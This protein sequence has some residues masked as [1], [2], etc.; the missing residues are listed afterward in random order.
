MQTSVKQSDSHAS[1]S[2]FSAHASP[3]PAF[4]APLVQAKCAACEHEDLLQQK[5]EPATDERHLAQAQSPGGSE[6]A[7]DGPPDVQA[8]CSACVNK[9]ID[10]QKKDDEHSLA[11]PAAP[12]PKLVQPKL[13]LGSAGD[14]F[15]QEA[16]RTADIVMRS[17]GSIGPISPAS[18]TGV[19]RDD[20]QTCT[21]GAEKEKGEE[22]EETED[23][24]PEEKKLDLKRESD[25]GSA[26]HDLEPRI[27]AARGGG[28]PLPPGTR[29]FMESRFGYDFSSVRIHAGTNAAGMNGDIRSLAFTSGNDIFFGAGHYRPQSDSG[30]HLLAHELTHVVQQ[31]GPSGGNRIVREKADP[32]MVSRASGPETKWYYSHQVSGTQVHGELE[33]M[34]RGADTSK[35]LVTEAAIPG[36][37]RNHVKLNNIGVAD[38]YK[39]NPPTTVTGIKG[40]RDVT[41][42]AEDIISMNSPAVT[43]TQPAVTSSP[44]LGLPA[45]VTKA[46][47]VKRVLSG[48]FPES[49]SLGEIKPASVSKLSD[50][51]AQLDHYE[52]GYREF[53][54]QVSKITGGATRATITTN[55]LKVVLPDALNFDMWDSQHAKAFPPA[56]FGDR[57]LWVAEVGHG[58]G[59]YLYE[60]LAEGLRGQPTEW[61]RDHWPKLLTVRA[62]LNNRHVGSPPMGQGKA[63]PSKT[64]RV[65]RKEP[66]KSV[67][68]ENDRK[69]FATKFR[70][71]I[72]TDFKKYRDKLKFEKKLGKSGRSL[73]ASEKAEVKEYKSMMFWSG[74]G[75]KIVGKV[76]FLLGGAWDKAVDIFESMKKKMHGIRKNV[77]EISESG[78]GG[79][80]WAKKLI[81]VVVAASKIAVSAFITESF[82][83]F[84]D[85][86]QSAMDKVVEKF[87]EELLGTELGQ[88]L[89]RAHK[90]FE[91]AKDRLE[92]EW[93]GAISKL[94]E[95]LAVIQETKRWIDIATTLIDLI[96]LGVQVISCLT[97]PALGCLWG[98]VAQ[99]GIGAA[100]GIVVGTQWFNDNIVTPQV[101]ALVRKYAA[102]H[103]QSLINRVLGEKLK[104]YHCHI[105]DTP[106]PS[107]DFEAKDGLKNGTKEMQ[108]HR[109]AWEKEHEGE[110]LADL[111]KV[112][113]G[114]DGKKVTK[115]ELQAFIKLVQAKK[116][117]VDGI[118]AVVDQARDPGSGSV[119]LDTATQAAE[120][121]A[122][123]GG[124]QP[125]RTRTIDYPK[126]KRS[127]LGSQK[128]RGWDP[129]TFYK[130]PLVKVDSDEFADAIY[131][132]QE[133][134]RVKADGMLGDETLI[135]FYDKNNLPKDAV[136]KESQQ[137]REKARLAAEKA[138]KEQAEKQREEKARAAAEKAKGPGAQAGFKLID[139]SQCRRP[140]GASHQIPKGVK[141]YIHSPDPWSF[142]EK[143]DSNNYH[144]KFKP[145]HLTLDI[146]IDDKHE[147]RVENVEVSA[148]SLWKLLT[149]GA[150]DPWSVN[151]AFKDGIELPTANGL[152]SIAGK[153]WRLN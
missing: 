12:L 140:P 37:N 149:T 120:K 153:D 66:D 110:M 28:E 124:G 92:T 148:F 16:D 41:D 69:D 132:L 59:I 117:N 53:V 5:A 84:A 147:Y 118:K 2:F 81:K 22:D 24:L 113:V 14:R 103:Y 40:I 135:A 50:G 102:P 42:P 138:A 8:K 75:G 60:D 29:E 54:A 51:W 142:I 56:T 115:E 52:Q 4:F 20:A 6:P 55:R 144:L 123:G 25:G 76:R 95:L 32:R 7:G 111:Q 77:R 133:A 90:Q 17:S 121:G 129:M 68:W 125:A 58:S 35:E 119:S 62:G 45:G 137:E 104:D 99:I 13:T 126:A 96:R 11:S 72:K 139:A 122:P 112:F 130:K 146:F 9:G 131:D 31:L 38:L 106:F 26:P 48:D 44:S 36:A 145:T 136:Y 1:R 47:G 19:Q 74:F 93:G 80:G 34:L 64:G 152:L 91:E 67:Q 21:F 63:M 27:D 85:C 57:R 70:G 30:R 89:C 87:K 97:P 134:L 49:V 107:M 86:F 33:R 128:M 65:Q 98:L 143:V 61:H 150:V 79:F 109:D 114:K 46:K 39:S 94:Q 18:P 88:Q 71:A 3:Q 73:P 105:A 78:V 141:I 15:E 10:L 127:N 43:R 100:L 151:A 108:D 101:R 23:R 82:N 116:L 83:F